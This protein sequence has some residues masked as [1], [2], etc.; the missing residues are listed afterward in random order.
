M[1]QALIMAFVCVL[2][3]AAV[4]C[5]IMAIRENWC[6]IQAVMIWRTMRRRFRWLVLALVLFCTYSGAD[7]GGGVG[8]L[9]R[10]LAQYLTIL[11]DGT[12]LGPTNQIASAAAASAVAAVNAESA[13]MLVIASNT[14][15]WAQTDIPLIEI[16]TTN[17]TI[18][19]LTADLPQPLSQSN[20]VARCDLLRTSVASNGT[21]SA[22]VAFNQQPASAPICA[23]EGSL[24]GTNWQTFAATSNSFPALYPISMPDGVVSCL[25]YTVSIPDSMRTVTVIPQRE[26]TFGGGSSNA[27]LQVLGA[28]MVDSQIGRDVTVSVATNEQWIFEGGL[29]VGV[30]TNGAPVP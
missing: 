2:G 27:P 14:L 17:T 11:S 8:S 28:V 3:L 6:R 1:I 22:F 15:Q 10:Y 5:G 13:N 19:W 12:M 21:I 30:L 26:M 23:F 18:A 25:E 7:K 20:L 4:F 29:L 16:D 9:S 24:D